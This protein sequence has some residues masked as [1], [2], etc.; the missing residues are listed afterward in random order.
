MADAHDT[1]PAGG[2]RTRGRPGYDLA[3]VL[4]VAVAVFNER[5]FDGTSMEDLS[6]RL[7]VTKSAI[8]HHVAGKDALLGLALDHALDGLEQIAAEVRALDA[9]AVQRLHRLVHGSVEVLV[10]RL[11][12][13]TL[14]LHVRG[15]T[16][17]ER[18]ALARRRRLDRLAGDLV[19]D[20]MAAGDVRADLDPTTTARL[21]FGMINSIVEW[22]RPQRPSDGRSLADVVTTMAFSGIAT[23][24]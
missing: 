9:P 8:Y 3:S 17:V 12:F 19:A 18:A 13:V 11:P 14:L 4:A 2:R 21:L 6:Q 16:D 15:N 24:A 20:A 7:G 1:A 5:G 23:R 22:Y 10:D